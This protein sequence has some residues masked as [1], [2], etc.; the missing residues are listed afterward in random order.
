MTFLWLSH[1]FLINFSLLSNTFLLTFL[2]LSHEFLMTFS[3]LSHDFPWLSELAMV[4]A[5]L[6]LVFTESFSKTSLFQTFWSWNVILS[7]IIC[8]VILNWITCFL[9]LVFS[10]SAQL[11]Q[12]EFSIH[13]QISLASKSR[14]K[15]FSLLIENI[16]LHKLQAASCKWLLL[17]TL[18]YFWLRLATFVYIWLRL[19][20][21]GYVWLHLPMFGYIWQYLA[22][23]GYVCLL[24]AT[25][26]TPCPIFTRWSPSPRK[27]YI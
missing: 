26:R 23:F 15:Y 17:T 4:C 3:W 7:Y 21:F 13:G 18:C 25:F 24:L 12:R 20:T 5:V 2:W 8:P 9:S 19:A 22:M 1:D 10:P 27:K 6:A 11:R 14:K 16:F